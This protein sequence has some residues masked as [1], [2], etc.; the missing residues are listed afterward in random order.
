MKVTCEGDIEHFRAA[1]SQLK[2]L[3]CVMNLLLHN[4]VTKVIVNVF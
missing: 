2:H 3:K 4:T 1:S